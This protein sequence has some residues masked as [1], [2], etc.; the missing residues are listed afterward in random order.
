MISRSLALVRAM[1]FLSFFLTACFLAAL[2][3]FCSSS[4]FAHN[5]FFCSTQ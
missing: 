4:S 5:S 3:F 1:S 2:N